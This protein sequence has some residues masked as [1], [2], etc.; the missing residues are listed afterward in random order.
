V[1]ENLHKY[2]VEMMENCKGKEEKVEAFKAA[3]LRTDRDF[4]ENVIKE[5]SLKVTCKKD[6]NLF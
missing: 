1:A 3:F 5:Q 2:V 4:L 6:Y